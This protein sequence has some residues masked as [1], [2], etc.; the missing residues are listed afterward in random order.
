MEDK[1]NIQELAK[2]QSLSD[3]KPEQ[4]EYRTNKKS[5]INF[6]DINEAA[7]FKATL[8]AHNVKGDIVKSQDGRNYSIELA[9][10]KVELVVSLITL[11]AHN[12]S[13]SK[14]LESKKSILSQRQVLEK[15]RWGQQG[16]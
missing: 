12:K 13:S 3:L 11:K 15:K 14:D 1:Q 6:S 16:F 8:Q 5:R 9:P 4:V 2:M 10:D 7:K